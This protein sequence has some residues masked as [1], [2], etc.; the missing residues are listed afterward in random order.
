[1]G[2]FS[3][4]CAVSPAARKR[5]S[6]IRSMLRLRL[7]LESF[8]ILSTDDPA[9]REGKSPISI[10]RKSKGTDFAW[11]TDKWENGRAVNTRP[12]HTKE[13]WLYLE[14]PSPLRPGKTYTIQTGDLAKNGRE[15]S[16]S[17]DLAKA[18]PKRSMSTRWAMCPPRRRNLPTCIIGWA[19]RGPWISSRTTA[20]SFDC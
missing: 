16:F 17:F 13:H 8:K 2:M 10:G 20:E 19:T 18:D 15:W 6:S 4:I 11:F 7:R 1:M 5:S 12:D 14:L 3:T 9:Y